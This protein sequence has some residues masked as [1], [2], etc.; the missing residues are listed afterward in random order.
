MDLR[1][2]SINAA[3]LSTLND[4]LNF[5]DDHEKPSQNNPSKPYIR[6]ARAMA[7]TPADVKE[8]PNSYVFIVGMPGIVAGDINVQLEDDNVLVVSAE[9][10]R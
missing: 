4:M 1:N 9:R 5:T 7:A 2:L 3:L 6:D 10:K 8:Y